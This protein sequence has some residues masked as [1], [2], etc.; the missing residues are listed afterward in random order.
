MQQIATTGNAGT[1]SGAY[2]AKPGNYGSG[3]GGGASYDTL[4]SAGPTGEYKGAGSGYTGTQSGKT[5]TSTGNNNSGASSGAD[6]GA[7]MY[8]KSHVALGKVNVSLRNSMINFI[9]KFAF[10]PKLCIFRKFGIR[11][12]LKSI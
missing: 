5:G 6:I 12:I 11:S 8:A 4:A 2:S 1:N 10:A 9:P 3:Y 7:T